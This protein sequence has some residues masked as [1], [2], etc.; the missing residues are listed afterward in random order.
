MCKSEKIYKPRGS[1]QNSRLSL[2]EF[3]KLKSFWCEAAKNF[4]IQNKMKGRVYKIVNSWRI[5]TN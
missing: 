2:K 4:L 1:G 3:C 5:F